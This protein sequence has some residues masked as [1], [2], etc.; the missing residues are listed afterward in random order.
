[1]RDMTNGCGQLVSVI[2]ERLEID[3]EKALQIVMGQIDSSESSQELAEV[4]E[5]VVGNWCEDICQ[6]VYTFESGPGNAG[7]ETIVVS[8]GGGFIE[9]LA[10]KLTAALK[11]AVSKINPFA[12]LISDSKELGDLEAYQLL[13]PI[14]LGLATRRVNDK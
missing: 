11:V 7:V 9:L 10:E 4:Y 13:A 14:A 2:S 3:R 5:M 8:G 12:G 1:M 6:V